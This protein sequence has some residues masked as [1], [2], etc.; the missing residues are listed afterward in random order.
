MKVRE[1]KN[2]SRLWV[3]MRGNFVGPMVEKTIESQQKGSVG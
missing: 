2:P 3:N 1:E